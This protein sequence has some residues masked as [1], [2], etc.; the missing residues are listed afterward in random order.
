MVIAIW[1]LYTVVGL[2]FCSFAFVTN[3]VSHLNGYPK[4]YSQGLIVALFYIPFLC[5][6]SLYLHIKLLCRPESTSE[7]PPELSLPPTV[8]ADTSTLISLITSPTALVSSELPRTA[9]L[10]LVK[11]LPTA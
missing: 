4:A 9:P 1:L 2:T 6:F 11:T 10:F 5:V 3:L 8:L 7:S